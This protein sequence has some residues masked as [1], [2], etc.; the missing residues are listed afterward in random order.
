LDPFI[1]ALQDPPGHSDDSFANT[2]IFAKEMADK[3]EPLC[4]FTLTFIMAIPEI[5]NTA[6]MPKIFFFILL[7]YLIYTL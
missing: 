6:T 4:E 1:Y 2:S 5:T 7:N 3:L